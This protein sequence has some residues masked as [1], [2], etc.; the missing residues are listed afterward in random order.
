MTQ[1]VSALFDS[2]DDA[3]IAVAAL[4]DA[5]LPPADISLI[6]NKI[7]KH[8]VAA[9]DKEG[10]VSAAAAG[11]AGIGSALGGST[12]LLAGLG[13]IVLPG[14]GPVAAIGWLGAMAVGAAAGALAGG[15]AGG[16][17]DTLTRS[18]I[19]APEA[20]VYA[21]GVKRGGTLVSVRCNEKRAEIAR[22]IF[23]NM[24][25]VDLETRAQIFRDNGWRQ[26][27]DEARAESEEELAR[28]RQDPRMPV[29]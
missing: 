22:E 7:D 11:G 29:L 10:G 12:G 2:Y 1:T 21:E 17:V 9:D 16:L 3:A 26:F 19:A 18:G 6:S 20:N 24:D 15:L 25:T 4:E 13:M 28:A 8:Y 5:G 14:I 27:D 23:D